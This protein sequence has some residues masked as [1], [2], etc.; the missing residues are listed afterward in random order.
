MLL[1]LFIFCTT[2]MKNVYLCLH[3]LAPEYLCDDSRHQF[4][5]TTEIIVNV[6]TDRT[7]NSAVH[8]RW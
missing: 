4:K 1:L 3:N 6:C 7:A 8:R 2:L 5:A